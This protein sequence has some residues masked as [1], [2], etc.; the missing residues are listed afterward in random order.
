MKYRKFG[1]LSWR[2]PALGFG[3][4][5][6][7]IIGEE[8][9]NVDEAEV[10]RM[11]VYGIEHGVNYID[12]GYRYHEGRSE[13]A[14][15]KILKEGYRDK[16]TLATKMPSWAIQSYGDFDRYLHEQLKRLQTDR[17]D[18]YLLHTLNRNLW[19]KLRDT[20]V[21]QWAERAIAD[22]L[23]GHLGFS[24]HDDF[25]IFKE[26]VDA[27]DKWTMCQGQYN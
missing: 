3:A 8:R 1:R 18:F 7:P 22:G 12:T 24:F 19:P 5:R 14:I 11:I 17:I 27:Y 13:A 10:R 21:L 9:T 23:I 26:I 4:M 20:G 15:G 6:L 25:P 2:G 16:V